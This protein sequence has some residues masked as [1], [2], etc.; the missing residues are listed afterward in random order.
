M[1]VGLRRAQPVEDVSAATDP[2][3]AV[4]PVARVELVPKLLLQRHVAF[5]HVRGQQPLEQ[6]VVAAV[7]LPPSEPERAGV[8][9]G[10]EHGAHDVGRYAEPVDLLPPFALEVE[11]RQ[12][13]VRADP[14]EHALGDL[15]IVGEEARRVQ[16][17]VPRRTEPR[18]FVGKDE[19]EALVGRFE[20]LAPFVEEVHHAAS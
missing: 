3:E 18:I 13:T 16:A 19:R 1:R 8:R 12:R 7:A 20:H 10:L 11:R 17:Q 6:V 5:E 14:L 2:E 9:I 4:R 15:A